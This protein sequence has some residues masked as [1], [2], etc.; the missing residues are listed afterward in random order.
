MEATEAETIQITVNGESKTV[1]HG[2][3]V[4]QLL[5]CL[6]IKPDRVAVELNRSIVRKQDWDAVVVGQGAEIEIVWF[7]GG[8]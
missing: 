6:E 4:A 5:A 1:P 2:L 3:T 7:V 8:G